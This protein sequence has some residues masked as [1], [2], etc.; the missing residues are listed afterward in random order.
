MVAG[1]RGAGK[2]FLIE[3]YA[4]GKV[5]QDLQLDESVIFREVLS[6]KFKAKKIKIDGQNYELSLHKWNA[7]EICTDAENVKPWKAD[8]LVVVLSVLNLR[9]SNP[10]RNIV[11]L[12]AST[13]HYL[14]PKAPILLVG[15]KADLIWKN[16][17][18][19]RVLRDPYAY[20]GDRFARQ[21]KAVKYLE[22]SCITG[23]G[24]R[25]VFYEAVWAT[26][27][28]HES[29]MSFDVM[30]KKHS[31]SEESADGDDNSNMTHDDDSNDATT[32]LRRK[33]FA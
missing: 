2:S 10:K 19:Q 12:I 17:T 32:I 3:C 33:S 1:L 15:N 11:D 13:Q 21:I 7:R 24:V 16:E 29:E 30:S 8:V 28:P 20:R 22:C 25:N 18:Y 23:M 27:Q 4:V 31:I 5:L 26:R 14:K 9:L 6:H